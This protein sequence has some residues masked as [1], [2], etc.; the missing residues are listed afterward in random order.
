M[1]LFVEHFDSTYHIFITKTK[2]SHINHEGRIV[3]VPKAPS[4]QPEQE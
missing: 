3:P 2:K 1:V 4:R